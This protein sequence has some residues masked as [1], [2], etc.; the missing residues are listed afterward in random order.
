MTR[1]LE[2]NR[3]LGLERGDSQ[4]YGDWGRLL[5]RAAPR[6]HVVQL[7]QDQ[8]FLNRAVC[9]PWH[10]IWRRRALSRSLKAIKASI[11]RRAVAP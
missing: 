5:A 1:P 3:D 2:S 8:G 6:D 11:L 7:Y 4:E 10:R 9:R